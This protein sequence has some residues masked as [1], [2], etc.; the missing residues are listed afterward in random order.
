MNIGLLQRN[1]EG[2]QCQKLFG[3]GRHGD[4]GKNG[5]CEMGSRLQGM[6]VKREQIDYSPHYIVKTLWADAALRVTRG[7]T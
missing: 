1:I 2:V 3:N 6:I 5:L 7:T 4:T